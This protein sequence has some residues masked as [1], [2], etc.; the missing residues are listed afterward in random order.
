MPAELTLSASV[1]YDDGVSQAESLSV[2]DLLQDV[3]TKITTR[4][5]QT[6]ATSDTAI[7]LGSVA[8]LG[9]MILVNR[10]TTNYVDV[11]V[12]AAGTVIARLRPNGGFCMFLVGSGITAPVA[13]ANTASCVIDKMICSL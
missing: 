5:Q 11:K 7:N 1:T 12:A 10:D 4:G 9:Y 13:I 2:A 3:T 6:I 8:T